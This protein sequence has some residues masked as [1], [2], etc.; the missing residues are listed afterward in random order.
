MVVYGF[1]HRF[2]TRKKGRT[3]R[4]TIN[5]LK[6]TDSLND[7]FYC[8]YWHYRDW[9]IGETGTRVSYFICQNKKGRLPVIFS[10]MGNIP[11][12]QR[13]SVRGGGGGG[14]G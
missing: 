7:H 5:K 1:K 10:R 12:V 6:A 2:A 3:D 9:Y 14:G 13:G 4:I 8:V 11:K